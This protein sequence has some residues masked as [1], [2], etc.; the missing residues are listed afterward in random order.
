MTYS[1]AVFRSTGDTLEEAQIRKYRSL[2]E[3]AGLAE[4][5]Q[6]L[7]IGCGWGGFA[8]F[9]AATYGCRVTGLTLSEAQ[10][11][12]A[13]QRV[14]EAGLEHL[15]DIRIQD[16]RKVDGRF[17][18]IVSIEMLEAV[19]HAYLGEFFAACER[20]LDEGGRAAIQVITIDD[21][22]YEAYRRRSDFIRKHIFP[23]GHL[24]SLQAMQNAIAKHSAFVIQDVENI[25]VHYAETLRRWRHTFMNRLPEVME[26]GFDPRFIRMWEFYLATCEASFGHGKLGTLQLAL[27]RP[28][29]A[30]AGQIPSDGRS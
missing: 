3:K 7:E 5:G 15:V 12:V 23:G 1:S 6:V 24:P 22:S 13:R 10:A 8:R 29:R 4:G 17:D 26:L 9:A 27:A 18:A 11:E 25:A 14:R 21:Q 2:A 20:L 30:A 16:Y 28:G 19:G